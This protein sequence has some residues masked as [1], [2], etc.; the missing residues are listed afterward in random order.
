MLK[1]LYLF[2]FRIVRRNYHAKVCSHCDSPEDQNRC[3][4]LGHAAAHHPVVR[5]IGAA[6]DVLDKALP[7]A[8]YALIVL[9]VYLYAL[10][11]TLSKL[12]SRNRVQADQHASGGI[13]VGS[14]TDRRFVGLDHGTS[15]ADSADP[16]SDAGRLAN[17]GSKR[18]LD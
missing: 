13:G 2:V 3:W 17:L 11:Y 18:G 8:A 1:A 10:D 15:D 16:Q 14:E 7:I 6:D 9:G 12:D 4:L 5:T